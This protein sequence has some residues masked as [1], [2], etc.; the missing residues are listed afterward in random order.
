MLLDFL[1]C[2]RKRCVLLI[3]IFLLLI[4]VLLIYF[5]LLL[6]RKT[7]YNGVI[8]DGNDV[9]GLSKIKAKELVEQNLQ[10]FLHKEVKLKYDNKVWNFNMDDISFTM[11]V[12][13]IIDQAYDVGRTGGIIDRLKCIGSAKRNNVEFFCE[14]RFD[15]DKLTGIL[16]QI[17]KE[18][19]TGEKNA[20][21]SFSNGEITIE[22]E[23]IG[24]ELNIDKNLKLV[25]NK[26]YRREFEDIELV[27]DQK[28]PDIVYEDIK[29]IKH[30]MSSFLTIFNLNDSNRTHNLR[31]ACDRINGILLKPGEIFSMNN[32]LGPRTIENGYKE[33]P[34]IFKNEL[35]KG[36]GGGICQVTTTL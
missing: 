36:P 17:K 31:L 10:E 24:K 20:S 16:S 1:L 26:I 15:K 28:T 30:V 29:E 9:S 3:T 14:S 35:I 13:D 7:F 4:A 22:K 32:A 6:S 11:L 8:I 21:V 19:D 5:L 27:V 12:E 2:K 25:E 23:T 33:A 34:V 18:I